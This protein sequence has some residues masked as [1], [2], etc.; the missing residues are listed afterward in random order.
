MVWG[1][2]DQDLAFGFGGGCNSARMGLA[3]VES[4]GPHRLTAWQVYNPCGQLSLA[5][6]PSWEQ[7]KCLRI[8]SERC[9]TDH[10]G[11]CWPGPQAQCP[12]GPSHHPE[13]MTRLWNPTLQLPLP[14]QEDPVTGQSPELMWLWRN[15][16]HFSREAIAYVGMKGCT[17]FPVSSMRFALQ[18]SRGW[19]VRES[20]SRYF[21]HV[22]LVFRTVCRTSFFLTLWSMQ[23]IEYTL[24]RPLLFLFILFIFCK[25]TFKE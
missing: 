7:E 5:S 19:S 11:P 9:V 12:Q 20:L 23:I 6:S 3:E 24:S 18:I 2:G 8:Y 1:T 13:D 17:S 22:S 15:P 14:R 21:Y 10:R 16:W 25:T 4:W